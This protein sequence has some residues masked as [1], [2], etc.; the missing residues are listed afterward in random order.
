[1]KLFWVA[2][3]A[4]ALVACGKHHENKDLLT[5]P[6]PN[7][8][9]LVIKA[10]ATMAVST[11][12]GQRYSAFGTGSGNQPVNVTLAP[13]TKFTLDNSKFV[14]PTMSNASLSFGSLSITNLLD[15]NLNTCGAAGNQKCNT[16]L[17]RIYTTGVAGAGLWNI[18]DG[19]GAP[20]AAT[21]TGTPLSVGLNPSGAAMMQTFTIPTTKHVLKLTDFSTPPKYNIHFDF[22]D[23]G[24]GS[25]TTTIVVEY[26]LA[27]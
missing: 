8:A 2:V 6:V 3:F 12:L 5:H 7:E 9:D 19:Y 24:A 15:N 13:N 10:R 14:I 4:L 16:A 22:S 20:M 23:A 27:P 18:A 21:L 11:E 25:F 1:M 26:A 17:L